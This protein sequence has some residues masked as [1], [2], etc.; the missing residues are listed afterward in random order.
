MTI[1]INDASVIGHR[2]YYYPTSLGAKR[3]VVEDSGE[4]DSQTV[5]QSDSQ[6]VRQS[7]SQSDSG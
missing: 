4:S 7:D 1:T 2:R 3:S 5:R 6:T